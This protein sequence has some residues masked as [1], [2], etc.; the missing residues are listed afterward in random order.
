MLAVLVVRAFAGVALTFDLLPLA[1]V[2]AVLAVLARR[3]VSLPSF[4]VEILSDLLL[5][6][7]GTS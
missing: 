7:L 1:C 5:G 2:L 3:P 6:V 4:S